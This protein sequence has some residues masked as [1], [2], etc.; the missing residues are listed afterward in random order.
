MSVMVKWDMII[1]Y[2]DTKKQIENL[3]LKRLKYNWQIDQF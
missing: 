3:D 1:N 2:L